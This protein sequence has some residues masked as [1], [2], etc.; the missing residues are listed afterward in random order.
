MEPLEYECQLT[1][2]KGNAG[3]ESGA[4]TTPNLQVKW[5]AEMD[6][7]FKSGTNKIV[8]GNQSDLL[9]LVIQEAFE[10]VWSV[11]CCVNAFP[12]A[13]EMPSMIRDSLIAAAESL[14]AASDVH[15]RLLSDEGYVDRMIHW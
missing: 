2:V 8:L 11:L 13:M 4:A 5:P 14:P 6:V 15:Q 10:L 3:S 1:A 12:N 9:R 7:V